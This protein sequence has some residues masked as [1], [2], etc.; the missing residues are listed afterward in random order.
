MLVG[1]LLDCGLKLEAL[2]LEL[3]KLNLSNYHVATRRVDRSGISATKFDVIVEAPG[4]EPGRKM[5]SHHSD[6]EADNSAEDTE[7]SPEHAEKHH[8]DHG[9][10]PDHEPH[11]HEHR[12]LSSIRQLIEHSELSSRVKR[13][14]TAIFQL[15]GEAEARVHN[16]PI[17]AVQFHEVGAIDSIIDIVGV[18]IGLELLNVDRVLCS[19]LHVGSGSFECAHGTYPVPGPA[20]CELLRG[21]PVYSGVIQGELVTPTGAAIVASIAEDFG[22]LKGMRIETTGYGAGAREYPRFPNVLRVFLGSDAMTETPT[23]IVVIETNVDDLN[24]QIF[25]YVI[26]RLFA[27][28]A[29]DVFYA[30]VSMKKSRPGILITV[31][32]RPE[33]RERLTS[34][35]FTETTTIGVRYRIEQRDVLDRSHVPVMTPFGEIRIKVARSSLGRMVNH[36]PEFEDCLE[37]AREHRVAL[38][39]VQMAAITAYLA[40]ARD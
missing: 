7:A 35:L 15:L 2:E 40:L 31:L 22:P 4:R 37:A 32:G 6:G 28:G 21:I 29:L 38:R 14:A 19:A 10:S 27:E 26:E 17:E 24:P 30:P 5:H 1:A 12:A 34:V 25:G 8:H 33:D 16:V 13:R 3:R 39:E 23:E 36:A 18:S 9:H 11:Q 20:T